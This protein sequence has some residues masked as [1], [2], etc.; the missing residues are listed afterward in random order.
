[1][2]LSVADQSAVQ[3]AVRNYLSSLGATATDA[4]AAPAV[5]ARWIQL[6]DT[7]F[8]IVG[9]TDKSAAMVNEFASCFVAAIV[10]LRNT[11]GTVGL[12]PS[13]SEIVGAVLD[14]RRKLPG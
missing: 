2:A 11:L 7:V 10:A 1:M 14:I 3:N 5:D 8:P 9:Y 6:R 4:A 12:S 13:A